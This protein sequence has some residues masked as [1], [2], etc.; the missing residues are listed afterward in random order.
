MFLKLI[1][2]PGF[3]SLFLPLFLLNQKHAF[4]QTN[5]NTPL[6]KIQS[7]NVAAFDKFGTIPVNLF[8]GTPDISIPLHTLSYGSINVPIILR[9]H[10]N[11]VRVASHP[12]W[13]GTGWDLMAGGSIN[14]TVRGIPDE[15]Y[16]ALNPSTAAGTGAYFLSPLSNSNTSSVVD[17]PN[18]NNPQVLNLD[19]DIEADEFTFNMLGHS[20]KFYYEGPNSGWKVISAENIKIQLNPSPDDFLTPSQVQDAIHGYNNSWS[21]TNK[22]VSDLNNNNAQSRA[23]NSF[24]LTTADGTRFIFGGINAV[25]FYNPIPLAAPDRDHYNFIATAWHLTKIIDAEN[26]EI[27]F[28]YRRDYPNPELSISQNDI[29][30]ACKYSGNI[31]DPSGILSS[32]NTNTISSSTYSA[33]IIWPMLLSAISTPNETVSFSSGVSS[34]KQFSPLTYTNQLVSAPGTGQSSG[35][36]MNTLFNNVQNNFNFKWEQLNDISIEN[37]AGE[38]FKKI[39]FDYSTNTQQRLTLNSL[40]QMDYLGNPLEQYQFAYNNMQALPLYDGNYSD[41]WGFYNGQNVNGVLVGNVA[42]FKKTDTNL[43]TTGLLNKITY[44]TGGYTQF[45]WEAH[46]YSQ[47]VNGDRSSLVSVSGPSYCGGSR[48]KQI[49]SYQANGDLVYQKDYYYVRGYNSCGDPASLT[50]SGIINALPQYVINVGNRLDPTGQVTWSLRHQ[51][52]APYSP[53]SYNGQDSYIGYDQVVEKNRDGSYSIHY[54]TSYGPDFTNPSI[55][56]FDQLPSGTLGWNLTGSTPDLNVPHTDLQ[57]ERGK[58]LATYD[59][60]SCPNPTL[61]RKM[62]NTYRSDAARFDQYIKRIEKGPSVGDANCLHTALKLVTANKLYTYD[63]YPVT[64]DVTT[65]DLQGNNPI[66]KTISFEYNASNLV[67]KKTMLNSKS[68]L[69]SAETIV[70]NT[71]YTTEGIDDACLQMSSD[72]VHILDRVIEQ[73]V[74]KGGALKV[75][76]Q[77]QYYSPV[78]GIFKPLKKLVQNG[79]NTNEIREQ[80]YQYDSRGNLQDYSKVSDVHEVFLWSYNFQYQVAKIVGASYSSVVGLLSQ[81]QIDAATGSDASM[82]ALFATLRSQLPG[83]FITSYTYRPL[84]GMTSMTD[85]QGRNTYYDYDGAGRLVA[86]RDQDNNVIKRLCYNYSG[87]STSC[88]LFY[89]TAQTLTKTKTCADGYVGTSVNYTV[90]AQIY[91]GS[92]QSDANTNAVNNGSKAA[93]AYAESNGSCLLVI[94]NDEQYGDFTVNNCSANQ[95][96]TVVR[97]TVSAHTYSSTVPGDANQQAINDVQTNGQTYA[98]LHGQC[99]CTSTTVTLRN[100]GNAFSYRAILTNN[101]TG[102]SF[103]YNFPSSGTSTINANYPPGS[104]SIGF[105]PTGG[106]GANHTYLWSMGPDGGSSQG[107]SAFFNNI[108]IAGTPCSLNLTIQ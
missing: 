60:T 28:S 62:V 77:T 74:F 78:S 79:T 47:Y 105:A 50:S 23:F 102:A 24:T 108:N 98:N 48:V 25:E 70:E 31:L 29:A 86:I 57:C 14:R 106:P 40:T 80:F 44:P 21:G 1:K 64:Q 11:S 42:S 22:V 54:F 49:A 84:F 2:T 76:N 59:Y 68:E 9:Y 17:G 99:L 73:S 75:M 51:Y 35:Q 20:G 45:A 32:N 7:P 41:H 37:S 33:T 88:S 69:A 4:S 65:Y 89:N 92:T 100:S 97:Y 10:S 18:W 91:T 56:H 87:Q 107:T 83:V 5:Q 38:K 90:P 103:T 16:P 34:A 13:M 85:P 30:Y 66:V 93:Q 94:W 12:G 3:W 39:H 52:M 95:V 55:T 67:T 58:L 72:G 53:M 96:G 71:K 8:T 43:V 46:D 6:V 63:Y 104:Y 101:T 19:N 27:D 81:S 82:R 36:I 15:Y 26:N 61:V